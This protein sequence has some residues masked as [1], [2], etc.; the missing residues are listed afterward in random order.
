MSTMREA[1]SEAWDAA[2]EPVGAAEAAPLPAEQ[3]TEQEAT[4]A[5]A[6]PATEAS[7]RDEKGRFAKPAEPATVTTDVDAKSAEPEPPKEA[8][9]PP[10]SWSAAAK[11]E[12]A[13]LNPVIQ[14]EVLK[15]EQDWD[16]GTAQRQQEAERINRYEK[17]IAPRREKLA[18]SGV[19]EHTFVERLVAAHDFL[20]REP[21]AALQYLARQYGVNLGAYQQPTGHSQPMLPPELQG[22]VQTVQTLQQEL[23]SQREA[24]EAR[25]MQALQEQVDSFRNAPEN[26]YFDNVKHRVAALLQSGQA[27]D[28]K[29]AYDM[30]CWADPEVRSILLKEQTAKVAQPDTRAK[31]HEAKKAGVSVTGAPGAVGSLNG[32]KHT[33]TREALAAAWDE[34]AGRA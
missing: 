27:Q 25:E 24:Q 8:I 1:L 32:A 34:Q 11:A 22:M 23:A 16:K 12:F 9:R 19:D 20:E 26:I 4:P 5:P 30:A 18:L 21:Q 2:A 33:S 17:L 10:A 29:E 14:R 7:G 15:R 13:T 6:E 3:P 28:L 31:A